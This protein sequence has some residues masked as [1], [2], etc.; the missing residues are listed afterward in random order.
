MS[1]CY[2]ICVSI[3]LCHYLAYF[4]IYFCKLLFR[5]ASCFVSQ[6]NIL[7]LK[8]I[9]CF[10]F[11]KFGDTVEIKTISLKRENQLPKTFRFLINMLTVLSVLW[12]RNGLE[13]PLCQNFLKMIY[14]IFFVD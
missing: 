13:K 1:F 11:V 6:K 7:S 5:D 14:K 2:Y 3:L 10:S 4:I 8:F 9:Y 12:L